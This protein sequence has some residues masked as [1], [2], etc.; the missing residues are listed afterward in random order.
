MAGCASVMSGLAVRGEIQWGALHC[1]TVNRRGCAPV[2]I[3]WPPTVRATTGRLPRPK[4]VNP[5]QWTGLIQPPCGDLHS[6]AWL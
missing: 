6:M 3:L 1:G 2:P 4:S 5:P